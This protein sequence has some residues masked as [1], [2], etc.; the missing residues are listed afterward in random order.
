MTE[1]S[2]IPTS[3][4]LP[5]EQQPLRVA[6]WDQL[7]AEHLTTATRPDRLRLHMVFAGST[8]IEQTVRDLAARESDCCSFFAFAVVPGP[9]SDV[10]LDV[11]V[12]PAYEKVLDAL[13]ARATTVAEGGGQ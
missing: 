10:R 9:G 7:F 5:T 12:A 11:E 6:E 8:Q 4:A 13:Q 2:W 1:P 3:C